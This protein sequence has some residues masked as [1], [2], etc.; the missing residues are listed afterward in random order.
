MP[1]PWNFDTRAYRR[2]MRATD[3]APKNRRAAAMSYA[4]SSPSPRE[5]LNSS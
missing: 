1:P 2:L 4:K 5:S 3:D